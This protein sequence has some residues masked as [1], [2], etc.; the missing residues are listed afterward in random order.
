MIKTEIARK[1]PFHEPALADKADCAGVERGDLIVRT[2]LGPA[3]IKQQVFVQA[4]RNG[5]TCQ[6]AVAFGGLAL[7]DILLAGPVNLGQ[8]T[9]QQV[10]ANA[11]VS[12]DI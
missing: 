6:P 4:H 9:K 8:K 12:A 7:R 10:R 1:L 5:G 3:T 11:I 2:A